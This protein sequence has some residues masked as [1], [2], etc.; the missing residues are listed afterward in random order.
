MS[1]K[2][3][4][5]MRKRQKFVITS[6]ILT[7]S[8]L[9]IQLAPL[10]WRYGLIFFLTCIAGFFSC[11][12]LRE[13]L[14]GIEWFMI[15]APVVL[16]T[17]G[18]GFFFILLPNY[19][20]WRGLVLILFAVGQYA[21]LLTGNIFSVAAIRTIALFRAALTV[22][23]VM[24]LVVG[25]LLYNTILSFRLP[26]WANGSIVAVVSFLLLMPSLWAVELQE[27]LTTRI[28]AFSFFLAVMVGILAMAIAFWPISLPVASIFLTTVLYVFLGLSQNHFSGR[29]FAKTIWEY[30]TIGMVVL[31]TMLFTAGWGG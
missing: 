30:V 10:E 17:A 6:F 31:I 15:P 18:M 11:W 12:S 14:S 19:W 20:L 25:F 21:L 26:F 23:F 16:F 5:T 29:L 13:G 9:A 27:K 28:I 8:I 3:L 24:T 2:Y 7:A 4:P 1:R 22:G